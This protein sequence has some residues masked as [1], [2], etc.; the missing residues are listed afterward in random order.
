MLGVCLL[1]RCALIVVRRLVLG[2]RRHQMATSVLLRA[3]HVFIAAICVREAGHRA[4]I[5]LVRVIWVVVVCVDQR[6]LHSYRLSCT[7]LV[8]LQNSVHVV[9]AAHYKALS[10]V[11]LGKLF[12]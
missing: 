12:V 10:R 9:E 7:I 1:S 5:L 3:H 8:L 11:R 4:E 2:R 6:R